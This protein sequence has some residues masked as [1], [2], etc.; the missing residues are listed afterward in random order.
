MEST[1]CRLAVASQ[2][3]LCLRSFQI[4]KRHDELRLRASLH[5][6]D[7]RPHLATSSA[8]DGRTAAAHRAGF[9]LGRHPPPINPDPDDLLLEVSR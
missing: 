5:R 3:A 2:L 7:R 4:L 8:Y 6:H 9:C 1:S